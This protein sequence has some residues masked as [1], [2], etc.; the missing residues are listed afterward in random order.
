MEIE[1]YQALVSVGISEDKAQAAADSVKREIDGRYSAHK[2]ALV[3]IKDIDGMET[4]IKLD[5]ALGVNR[6]Q[7]TI[8]ACC[9]LVVTVLLSSSALLYNMLKV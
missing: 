7:N 4:R 8:Y 2:S 9:A 6:I 3:T 1:L 5:V